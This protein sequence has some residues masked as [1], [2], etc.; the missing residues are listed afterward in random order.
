MNSN[1]HQKQAINLHTSAAFA[2]ATVE[3]SPKRSA[4]FLIS[5]VKTGVAGEDFVLTFFFVDVDLKRIFYE[6]N[7]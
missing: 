5:S 3:I 1:Y 4:R 7:N 6:M 2:L